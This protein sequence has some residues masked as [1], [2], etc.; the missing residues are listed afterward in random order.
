MGQR[1]RFPTKRIDVWA[2]HMFLD[3]NK[4]ADAWVEKGEEWEDDSKVVGM[5]SL[6]FVGS[7]MEAVATTYA[8]QVC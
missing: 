7:G 2:A 4:E 8:V 6:D 1:R 5:R 3:H